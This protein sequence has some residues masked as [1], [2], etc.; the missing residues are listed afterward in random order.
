MLIPIGERMAYHPFLEGRFPESSAGQFHQRIQDHCKQIFCLTDPSSDR[1]GNVFQIWSVHGEPVGTVKRSD[2]SVRFFS[3][4]KIQNP[5]YPADNPIT[6]HTRLLLAPASCSW[7]YAINDTGY[8]LIWPHL[9][10][11]GWKDALKRADGFPIGLYRLCRTRT[12]EQMCQWFYINGYQPAAKTKDHQIKTYII[13]HF[14]GS[15]QQYHAEEHEKIRDFI[16]NN[17]GAIIKSVQFTEPSKDEIE[18]KYAGRGLTFFHPQ[19][20]TQATFNV[21]FSRRRGEDGK[22]HP[23][24]KEGYH[25]D[26]KSKHIKEKEIPETRIST[27][28]NFNENHKA[29]KEGKEP[30]YNIETPH[31][32][33]RLTDPPRGGGAGGGGGRGRP[34]F[35]PPPKPS[36]GHRQFHQT[37]QQT[38]LTKSFNITHPHNPAPEKGG[39]VGE[40]GGVAC[41]LEYFKGLFDTPGSL[42]EESHYFCLPKVEDS[43]IPFSDD[44][45]KQII[46]ELAIG[47]Y[48]HG[49]IPFF[50]LHFNQDADMFPVI[51]PAYANTLVGRVISLLD[52]F[53]K[54]YL[55]GGT[56]QEEFI[57]NWHKNPRWEGRTESA[58]SQMIDF[59][60]YCKEHLQG[61]DRNYV[62]LRR[63]MEA[64]KGDWEGETHLLKDFTEFS[65][66]FRIIARQ[67]SVQKADDLFILDSDFDVEYT[68]KPSP[69]YQ[70]ALDQYF[71]E[72]GVLPRSYTGMVKAF[73]Q[74][75]MRIH[76]HMVKLPLF[77]KYFP[78][79][80]V[81]NFLC[82]YFSTLKKHRRI[83]SLEDFEGLQVKG[84]PALF[85]HLPLKP[86]REER[87]AVDFPS[88]VKDLISNTE[89]K[90]YAEQ[91]FCQL[92]AY[93]FEWD[94]F[95]YTELDNRWESVLALWKK[96]FIE[97][98]LKSASEP[99]KK[100][101]EKENRE[102][103][104]KLAQSL[105]ERLRN[106]FQERVNRISVEQLKIITASVQSQR[107]AI[108]T[109]LTSIFR[110]ISTQP[111]LPIH[112]SYRP[113]QTQSDQLP[114]EIK[115]G[116]RI[117]GGVGMHL[118]SMAVQISQ[119]GKEIWERNGHKLYTLEPE[120]WKL[121]K[122]DP[123]DGS[124]GA[125]FRLDF[126]EMPLGFDA[127]R[128]AESLYET[129][130]EEAPLQSPWE[131]ALD[132]IDRGDLEEFKKCV[133]ENKA[134]LSKTDTLGRT[135]LHF[136]VMQS[137]LG[138]TEF[139][140]NNR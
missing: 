49:T 3:S 78:M 128:W 40:I 16:K 51:H 99:A 2:G 140:L 18:R 50:S 112:L 30:P 110:D 107:A 132:A 101:I 89:F 62:S 61:E 23:Q 138:F 39:T 102:E 73:D 66:S 137:N 8:L 87:F 45:L 82:G 131:Q 32:R 109:I 4:L 9:I 26:V 24:A 53:M 56:F 27:R 65:N 47:I 15:D 63:L 71:R 96:Q 54:G 46:R 91:V 19:D 85:P 79:L 105:L 136:V 100:V 133:T 1:Q 104:E 119:K 33:S 134:L 135:L 88:L 84:A 114:Q 120:R 117:V 57:D 11:S 10:A 44:E 59:E 38:G 22:W 118:E 76:D 31:S 29:R 28:E 60:A 52:Y 92:A 5:L 41:S 139:L 127:V 14:G 13:L 115:E 86:I 97:L 121:L 81:I 95:I 126:E 67:R 75:K 74:I 72:H 125:A 93:K 6:L 124:R 130:E 90:E 43:Q 129:S 68:I 58:L 34:P 103:Y 69:R 37:L 116:K 36:P 64:V 77:K 12:Q 48:G 25:I 122:K 94:S 20:T 108:D 111:L 70:D 98:L 7:E 83:P 80:G 113:I 55:N 42:F 17:R 21:D 123:L 35:S 106:S